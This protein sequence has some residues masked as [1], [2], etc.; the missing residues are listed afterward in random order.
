MIR[1]RLP[2][3]LIIGGLLAALCDP[4]VLAAEGDESTA[5]TIYSTAKPGAIPPELYRPV[6]GGG[7]FK[8]QFAA[9]IPGYAI[10]KH[11]RLVNLR[12]GRSTIRFTDV[13]AQIDPTTVSFAS[14]TDPAG[15]HV[16]EQN[17]EFDLV[18]SD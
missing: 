2:S 18:S 10:I 15:T 4:A 14:L 6:L 16:L 8:P 13:A 9:R 7:G 1:L 11:E 12:R 5:L 3:V 17:F